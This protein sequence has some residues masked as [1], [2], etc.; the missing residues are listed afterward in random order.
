MNRLHPVRPQRRRSLVLVAGLCAALIAPLAPSP[1][2]AASDPV[3][4]LRALHPLRTSVAFGTR[5]LKQR[6]LEGVRGELR[7]L[8]RERDLGKAWALGQPDWNAAEAAMAAPLL[9]RI[10]TEWNTMQWLE[11][12]W[13]QMIGGDYALPEVAT[14]AKHFASPIGRKQAQ[15][16]DQTVAFHV[17]GAYSMAGKIVTP[18]PGIEAEQKH[19]TEV[20][21][22]EDREMRFSVAGGDNIEAQTF[23]LSPLGARYQKTMIIKLTGLLNARIAELDAS[24]VAGARDTVSVASPFVERFA[25]ESGRG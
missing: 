15:I 17:M 5:Y 16:I 2:Q 6:A 7:R 1:A 4:E 21:A 24:L 9:A 19:L 23:A 14:L 3:V 18:Y 11:P 10:E 12:Q 8:G 13:Q 22:V 25:R 20:Y